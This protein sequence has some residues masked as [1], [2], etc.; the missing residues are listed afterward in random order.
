MAS[1][2]GGPWG[3][4]GHRGGPGGTN[5]SGGGGRRPGDGNEPPQV[6]EIDELMRKG[7]ERLRVLMGGGG[8]A[9]R[10]GGEGGGGGP[11]FGRGSLGLIA[12]ALVAA[13]AFASFYRVDTSEQSIELLFGER[14][15]VGTE[16]LNFA[17]WPIV[18]KEIYPVTRENII[19]VGSQL[20]NGLMLTGDENIVDIDFQVVW[21]IGNI[22][23]FIFNLAEPVNTI[24]AVSESAMRE[25]VARSNLAPILN[26]DRESIA[27]EVEALIQST[28][29][30][31]ESG[32]NIVRVNFD[33]A[34]PPPEVINAFR[35]VQAAKQTRDTLEKQADAYANQVVAGARG[36]AAQ[37]LEQAEG[38][39]AQVV[40]EA[41]GEAAR[42]ISVYEEYAKAED[43]TRKRLYL[44]TLERVLGGVEKIIIDEGAQ[45]GQG[46]VPYLP[47]NELRRSAPSST[48]T[49]GGSN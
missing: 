2:N 37:L 39:R 40:N 8:D 14:Y 36:E 42:F 48:T 32:V 22:E 45:G 21:N 4:G 17:P 16:G 47:L 18:T 38:Y 34:D 5:G 33:K 31:Y 3:G 15:K 27:Q 35:D 10:G 24:T 9:R 46:V 26:R 29:T 44:E 11:K 13:W 49:S 12:L 41:E 30:S 28:L 23:D 7:Q 20:D 1:D 25:I 6:P 19:N 43:V